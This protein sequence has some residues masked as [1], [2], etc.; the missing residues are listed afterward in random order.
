MIPIPDAIRKSFIT[1][2]ETQKQLR[3][4]IDC[5]PPNANIQALYIKTSF[6][7]ELIDG[8]TYSELR[9]KFVQIDPDKYNPTTN[10]EFVGNDN[11]LLLVFTLVN[12]ARD[13]ISDNYNLD[14]GLANKKVVSDTMLV[15]FTTRYEAP[16]QTLDKMNE[17]LPT[18]KV[19]TKAIFIP[20]TELDTFIQNIDTAATQ[21]GVDFDQI[22]IE[23][24]QVDMDILDSDNQ[25]IKDWLT[26]NAAY[27]PRLKAN[28]LTA[29]Y[30]GV[31]EAREKIADTAYYDVSHLCPPGSGCD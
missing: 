7:K 25:K 29:I 26:S 1:K 27:I 9:I 15:D 28:R 20:K 2:F 4:K 21:A 22:H 5:V 12:D 16:G 8:V 30:S 24:A 10:P 17:V 14:A 6:L 23:L 18:D 3:D 13:A 31:V 11:K 19:N